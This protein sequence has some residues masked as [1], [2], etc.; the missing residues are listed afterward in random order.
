MV[1]VHHLIPEV[2]QS[3]PPRRNIWSRHGR[4]VKKKQHRELDVIKHVRV[5]CD[6][7]RSVSVCVYIMLTV[8]MHQISSEVIQN[9]KTLR[10]QTLSLNPFKCYFNHRVYIQ[11]V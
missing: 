6:Q 11:K 5:Q 3:R 8:F 7:V 10:A 9:Q 4:P 1:S 2:L